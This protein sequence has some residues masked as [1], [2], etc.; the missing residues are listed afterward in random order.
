MPD[1]DLPEE[2]KARLS[3]ELAAGA[4]LSAPLA[5]QA[6]YASAAPAAVPQRHLRGRA[7]ALGAAAL[8]VLVGATFAGPTQPRAWLLTTVGNIAGDRGAPSPS[9]ANQTGH[10][11]SPSAAS[12]R[13]PP[14]VSAPEQ[15]ES[16]VPG[17]SPVTH[18]TPEPTESPAGGDSSGGDG[19]DSSPTASPSPD[20]SGDGH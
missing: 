9:P 18:E 3:A 1:L 6:R 5:S 8:V 10:T 17:Q 14:A 16:P 20:D 2:L 15:H 7:L 4:P 12:H 19:D 13:S 11:T